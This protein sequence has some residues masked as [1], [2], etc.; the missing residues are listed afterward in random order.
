MKK[1]S[2][3]GVW[4]MAIKKCREDRYGGDGIGMEAEMK[5]KI[6]GDS[7]L[8]CSENDRLRQVNEYGSGNSNG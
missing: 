6:N 1:F 7:Y 4:K 2:W 8:V 5:L 3:H